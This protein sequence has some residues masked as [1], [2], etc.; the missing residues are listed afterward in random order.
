MLSAFIYNRLLS[1]APLLH[2]Y[3]STKEREQIHQVRVEIKKTRAVFSFLKKLE[4]ERSYAKRILEHL[5][6][7]AGSLRELQLNILLLE[8]LDRPMELINELKARE[9]K[10]V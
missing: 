6:N 4:G 9:K 5:F 1:I 10:E 7:V 2:D 3:A 8:S